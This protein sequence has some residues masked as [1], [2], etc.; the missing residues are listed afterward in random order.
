MDKEWI[1]SL[2]RMVGDPEDLFFEKDLR[3]PRDEL[4]HYNHFTWYRNKSN[5]SVE[6]N[7]FSFYYAAQV[8]YDGSNVSTIDRNNP[9]ENED[10][11]LLIGYPYGDY[12]EGLL[13]VLHFS[14]RESGILHIVSAS[15]VE[16]GSW[17]ENRYAE[18]NKFRDRICKCDHR[19]P[20]HKRY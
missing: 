5:E 12:S 9:N 6:S 3:L 4:V 16:K 17:Y 10:R 13:V 1:L 18:V 2:A 7:R 11:R 20:K 19:E 8:D 15:P 14:L